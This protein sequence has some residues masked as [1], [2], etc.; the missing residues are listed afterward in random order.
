M[1]LVDAAAFQLAKLLN[2]PIPIGLFLR[3]AEYRI[4]HI[5]RV[6]R[7]PLIRCPFRLFVSQQ[8]RCL[9]SLP[10]ISVQNKRNLV[11]AYKT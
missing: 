8:L 9:Y 1:N 6:S 3:N 11:R 10:S 7:A 4:Y 2:H 5:V